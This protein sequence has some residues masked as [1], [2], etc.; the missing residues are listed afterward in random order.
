MMLHQTPD[1]KKVLAERGSNGRI[2]SA[3]QQALQYRNTATVT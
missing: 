1:I 3:A 2:H